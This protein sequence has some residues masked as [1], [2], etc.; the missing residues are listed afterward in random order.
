MKKAI[1]VITMIFFSVAAIAQRLEI[2]NVATVNP[3]NKLTK[4]STDRTISVIHEKYKNSNDHVFK[5][6]KDFHSQ[7]T[8]LINDLVVAIHP[9]QLK[10]PL[11]VDYLIKQKAGMDALSKNVAG[12]NS[13]IETINGRRFLITLLPAPAGELWTYSYFTAD[14]SRTKTIDGMMPFD[15]TDSAKA[16]ATLYDL[17]KSLKFK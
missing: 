13:Y 10:Q 3:A 2:N 6:L 14:K 11:N 15:A 5:V 1:C 8:Y 16:K 4:I 7:D 9:V 17:L 12:Y